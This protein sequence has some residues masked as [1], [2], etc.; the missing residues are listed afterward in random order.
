MAQVFAIQIFGSYPEFTEGFPTV[1]WD[2]YGGP[3]E[4]YGSPNFTIYK[5]GS[6]VM[7]VAANIGYTNRIVSFSD[8]LLGPT[9]YSFNPSARR[10]SLGF[11][12]R[13]PGTGGFAGQYFNF[14]NF[15][16]SYI[17]YADSKGNVNASYT[18]TNPKNLRI[19]TS[20]TA[21]QRIDIFQQ[22]WSSR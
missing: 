16:Y 9:N 20:T 12:S 5:Y 3:V 18:Q 8:Q 7:E 4:T 6:E 2:E 10:V 11:Q 13:V 14:G 19:Q 17:A 1:M 15:Q 21:G 22:T